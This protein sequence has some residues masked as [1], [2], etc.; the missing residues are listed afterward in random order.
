MIRYI[1]RTDLLQLMLRNKLVEMTKTGFCHVA[2]WTRTESM[3]SSQ[4]HDQSDAELSYEL[5]IAMIGRHRAKLRTNFSKKT[6]SADKKATT[7][8]ILPGLRPIGSKL[9]ALDSAKARS[10]SLSAPLCRSIN[11]RR[12]VGGS[13][14]PPAR[15]GWPNIGGTASGCAKLNPHHRPVSGNL[16]Q[17]TL[18]KIIFSQKK[19]FFKFDHYEG[20]GSIPLPRRR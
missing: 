3:T 17:I 14:L 15:T 5:Q 6:K 20:Q 11:R 4:L 1:G 13:N 9:G 7:R 12:R 2:T 16:Y 10:T 19:F 8:K 18:K